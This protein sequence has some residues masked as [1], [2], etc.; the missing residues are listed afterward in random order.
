MQTRAH[1]VISGR[2]QGMFFRSFVRSE[3]KLLN[4]V[5]WVRNM[6]TGQVEAVFEGDKDQI[7]DLI[8]KC[9]QG[10]PGAGVGDISVEWGEWSGTFTDFEIR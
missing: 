10:P 9:K 5:G 7:Q 6:S 8:E 1:I 3:S 4:I 2:V